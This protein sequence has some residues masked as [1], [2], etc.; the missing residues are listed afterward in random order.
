MDMTKLESEMANSCDIAMM[1][2]TFF[3]MQYAVGLQNN[4]VYN[5]PISA[6]YVIV[7]GD[8]GSTA[9][10]YIIEFSRNTQSW[11][12]WQLCTTSNAN[13]LEAVNSLIN[14]KTNLHYSQYFER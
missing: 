13:K 4:S 3:P 7:P 6:M 9:D 12:C 1:K 5:E 11:Q 2:D 14:F 10:G 8:G